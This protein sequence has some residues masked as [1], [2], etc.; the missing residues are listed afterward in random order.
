MIHSLK[1]IYSLKYVLQHILSLNAFRIYQ[2]PTRLATEVVGG[3]GER[4]KSARAVRCQPRWK[5]IKGGFYGESKHSIVWRP[6]AQI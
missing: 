1:I 2:A 4:I 3:H 5:G 6:P